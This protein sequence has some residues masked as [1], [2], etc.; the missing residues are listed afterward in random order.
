M[1]RHM[2]LVTLPFLAASVFLPA[3]GG[4]SGPSSSDADFCR[5]IEQLENL[6]IETD[7]AAAADILSDLAEKAPNDDVRGALELIA[8]I[9]EQLSTVDQ[10]DAAAM[11]EIFEMMSSPEVTA[12]SEVLDRYGSDVCGFDDNN[13]ESTS[14]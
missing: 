1:S 12:A 8:P 6:N 10:N 4:D 13:S 5:E 2:R 9:F 7:I 3:C 11:Q 14:P